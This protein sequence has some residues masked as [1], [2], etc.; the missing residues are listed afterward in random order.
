MAEVAV[1]ALLQMAVTSHQPLRA[2]AR[3]VLLQQSLVWFT[4]AAAP[5]VHFLPAR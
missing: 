2:M 4:E 3:P 1:R 5:E